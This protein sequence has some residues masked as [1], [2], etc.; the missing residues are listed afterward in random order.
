MTK[1]IFANIAKKYGVDLQLFLKGADEPY[2]SM[3]VMLEPENFAENLPTEP[4]V[5]DGSRYLCYAP[6]ELDFPEAHRGYVLVEN[7]KMLRV[8]AEK[9]RYGGIRYQKVVLRKA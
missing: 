3:R 2:V 7:E 8:T 6:E 9:V 4:G 1:Y 5:R